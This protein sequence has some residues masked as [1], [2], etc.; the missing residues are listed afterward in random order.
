[1]ALDLRDCRIAKHTKGNANGVKLE[2]PNIRVIN[3]GKFTELKTIDQ[4]VEELFVALV[5]AQL[6]RVG[7]AEVVVRVPAVTQR[8]W[9]AGEKAGGGRSGID[10]GGAGRPDEATVLVAGGV[11]GGGDGIARLSIPMLSEHEAAFPSL[12]ISS[13]RPAIG[14]TS[15]SSVTRRFFPVDISRQWR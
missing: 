13:D 7:E 10:P 15:R 1:M 5:A 3:K 12:S 6:P 2:R 14:I 4:V 9:A 8:G 11:V